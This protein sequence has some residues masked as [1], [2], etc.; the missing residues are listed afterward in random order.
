MSAGVRSLLILQAITLSLSMT[1]Q[2]AELEC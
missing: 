1:R 2:S